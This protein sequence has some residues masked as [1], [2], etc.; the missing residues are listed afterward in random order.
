MLCGISFKV[1]FQFALSW[2]IWSLSI[3]FKFMI[4][5]KI[6]PVTYA[7]YEAWSAPLWGCRCYRPCTRSC[8]LVRLSWADWTMFYSTV[9]QD[10]IQVSPTLP[11]FLFPR[12]ES[13]KFGASLFTS[14]QDSLLSQLP[15]VKKDISCMVL[16]NICII[17]SK[18]EQY[19]LSQNP[20]P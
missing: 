14:E 11:G 7:E 16:P 18:I 5:G 8:S 15:Q 6:L 9:H 10:P 4:L 3:C 20:P 13:V 2:C 1:F 12:K 19:C 17:L